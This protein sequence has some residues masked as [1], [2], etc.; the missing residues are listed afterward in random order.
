[1]GGV[2]VWPG[3]PLPLGASFD[4]AGTTFSIFSVIAPEGAAA[5][6]RRNDLESVAG[7]LRLTAHDLKALGLADHVVAEPSGGAHSDPHLAIQTVHDAI[8]A[9]FEGLS[10]PTARRRKRWRVYR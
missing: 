2:T 3:L 5:I 6:L 10:G 7:E 9:S 1:M 4:G 8:Q